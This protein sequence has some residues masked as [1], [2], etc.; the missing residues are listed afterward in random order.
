M[1]ECV[2]DAVYI[3]EAVPEVREI[4]EKVFLTLDKFITDEVILGTSTSAMVPS[5]FTQHMVHR[6]QVVV[7]HPVSKHNVNFCTYEKIHKNTLYL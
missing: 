5:K 1:E 7:V 4:K 3:Q 6:S 2:R